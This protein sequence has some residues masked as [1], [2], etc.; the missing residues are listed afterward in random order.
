[1]PVNW[2]AVRGSQEC[3][4]QVCNISVNYNF[5]VNFELLMFLLHSACESEG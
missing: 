3:I 5:Q 2:H 4:V 1:M